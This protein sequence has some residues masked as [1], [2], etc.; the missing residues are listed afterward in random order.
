MARVTFVQLKIELAVNNAGSA[1]SRLDHSHIGRIGRN[2]DFKDGDKIGPNRKLH[3]YEQ[4][5]IR[6]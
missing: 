5:E 1:C 6:I 4:T 2:G 3:L